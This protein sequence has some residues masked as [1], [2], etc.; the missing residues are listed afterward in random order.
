MR[1]LQILQEHDNK[2]VDTREMQENFQCDPTTKIDVSFC[3]ETVKLPSFLPEC[4]LSCW[5][6]WMPPADGV[7]PACTTPPKGCVHS[8]C[9]DALCICGS[10]KCNSAWDESC[11]GYFVVGY[12]VDTL[13]CNNGMLVSTK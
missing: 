10:Y 13:F 5:C 9:Q 1:S 3:F 7:L 8:P 11:R 12:S 2:P 6:L 4:N